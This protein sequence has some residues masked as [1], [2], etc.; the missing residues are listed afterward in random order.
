MRRLPP[1]NA[2][3]AFEAAAR[4]LHFGRA[5]DEL[6]VTPTAISHQ[7]R[8]LEGLLGVALFRRLPRPLSLTPE[9]AAL[10]PVL[11]DELDRMADE[12]AALR[13]VPASEPL[14]VSCSQ[15]FAVR[16]LM[17]RLAALREA[18]GLDLDIEADDHMV[19]LH[20]GSVDF[21]IRYVAAP[22]SDLAAH[23]LFRDSFVPVCAPAVLERHGPVRRPADVMR[24]PLVLWRW[25]PRRADA[26][27]W[28][29]WLHVA[30]AV[31][32][33][34][35]GM[36]LPTPALR[37]SGEAHA[38]EAA[39]GGHG[40]SLASDVGVSLDVQ[41]GRLTQ[42]SPIGIPGLTFHAVH[43]KDFRR[44]DDVRQFVAWVR[45]HVDAAGTT[46]G[47]E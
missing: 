6:A 32:P 27:S 13:A 2:L 12:I 19:D 46:G 25:T 40:V 3:R 9:G 26:P 37:L 28:E 44:A 31:D 42:A 21:A 20:A 47:R 17:P 34:C 39:L 43:R 23:T 18:T 36:E 1:L 4:H 33:D 5:A 8:L 45:A 24:L 15:S 22:A 11:R 14:I 41:A 7:V 35:A 10:F 16:W 38:I 30:A 29:R